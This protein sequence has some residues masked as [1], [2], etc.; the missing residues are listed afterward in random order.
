MTHFPHLER[1]V[2][3]LNQARVNALAR[4]DLTRIGLIRAVPALLP[5]YEAATAAQQAYLIGD[6][7]LPELQA[8]QQRLLDATTSHLNSDPVFKDRVDE[9]QELEDCITLWED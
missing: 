1:E 4:I 7:P 8:V 6:L 5:L 2:N 9:L 3:A